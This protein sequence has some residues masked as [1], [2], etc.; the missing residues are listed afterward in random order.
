MTDYTMP[1]EARTAINIIEDME[2]EKQKK[3]QL[4]QTI[5]SGIEP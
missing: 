3:E 1:G 5:L 2:R 4:R